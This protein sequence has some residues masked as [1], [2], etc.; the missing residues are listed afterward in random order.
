MAASDMTAKARLFLR[1]LL[2]SAAIGLAGVAL[3]VYLTWPVNSLGANLK[4][5]SNQAEIL[6]ALEERVAREPDPLLRR[7]FEAWHAEEQGDLAGAIRGFRGI[8]EATD[9]A[10]MLYVH[11][12]L[13]LGQSYGRNG[14][15]DREL[16]IYQGLMSRHPGASRLSQAFF[17]LRRGERAEALALLET[18]VAQDA[19]DGSL[20]HYAATA[21]TIRNDLRVP[22]DRRP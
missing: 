15:P 13:R 7:F 10:G 21:R 1:M 20:G 9:E 17:H 5:R 19:A 4:I 8:R 22:N 11:A 16:A 3:A 12:S 18:A 6:R 14:E 2:G